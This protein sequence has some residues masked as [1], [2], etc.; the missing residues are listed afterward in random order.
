MAA[1]ILPLISNK[2]GSVHDSTV[3]VISRL[4]QSAAAKAGDPQRASEILARVVKR[5]YLLLP[6]AFAVDLVQSYSHHQTA[7]AVPPRFGY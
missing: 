5:E 3:G 1:L 7:D 2:N 4:L 6:G